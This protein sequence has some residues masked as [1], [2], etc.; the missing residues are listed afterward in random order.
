MRFSTKSRS[1]TGIAAAVVV[2]SVGAAGCGDIV[3]EAKSGV[4]KAARTR[5]VF[6]LDTGDCYNPSSGKTEG[7]EVS[8]EIVPCDEAHEGQVVGGF[9]IEGETAYPGDDG[10]AAI[11][12]KRCPAES[13][14]YV[15]DTWAVP[16]GVSLFYYYPTAASWAT[17]D[18][19]VSCTYAKESGTF[20]GSLKN[21]S[22]NADQLAYLKGANN[23][24]EIL[25]AN[26]PEDS[27]VEKDFDGY[28]KQAGEVATALDAHITSLKAIDQP[29]TAKL[30]GELEKAAEA[31]ADA[32]AAKDTDSFYVAYDVAFTGIDPNKT[33]AART[34]LKLATTV[35]ADDAEV[36]AG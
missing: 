3:E 11:A 34:E 1:L 18:R 15:S 25:W 14:T 20:S 24:Y 9:K 16:E 19:S 5:S 23:L 36:W 33:V 30:R 8:V 26:Q 27:D 12:E 7:E 28:K 22:L 21:E 35:P 13:L 2:L 31:W 29:E 6:S 17:G 32:A 10:A 4:K